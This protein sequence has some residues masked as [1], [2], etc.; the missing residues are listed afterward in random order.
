MQ[1]TPR[2]EPNEGSTPS[3]APSQPS[4]P[5]KPADV[6]KAYT[7]KTINVMKVAVVMEPAGLCEKQSPAD[8]KANTK[9]MAT[10]AGVDQFVDFDNTDAQCTDARRHR[11]RRATKDKFDVTF[12]FKD[13]V[14][15]DTVSTL[16]AKVTARISERGLTVELSIGGVTY[17]VDIKE[18]TQGTKTVKVLVVQGLGRGLGNATATASAGTTTADAL[19][20]KDAGNSN[21]TAAPPFARPKAAAGLT[22]SSA[23]VVLAMAALAAVAHVSA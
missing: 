1:V 4:K 14:S 13:T 19:L 2:A 18:V 12:A 11:N 9:G 16:V 10:A 7:E 6:G 15:A 17:K 20:A 3:P 23:A 22:G 8:T 5:S 21:T